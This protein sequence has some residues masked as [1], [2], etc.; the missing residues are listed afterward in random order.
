MIQPWTK[1]KNVRFDQS[2]RRSYNFGD[3]RFRKNTN[4]ISTIAVIGT[5]I[6]LMGTVIGMIKAFFALGEG[7]G[8]PDAAKLSEG[9]AE[10]L[11]NTGTGIGASALAIIIY[12]MITNSIDDLTFKIDEVGMAIQQS[13]AKH[14]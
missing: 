13:F 7:G 3:A 1:S 11:I 9:I 6:A 8:T 4:I 5:L 10:A 14:H 2:F 12:N